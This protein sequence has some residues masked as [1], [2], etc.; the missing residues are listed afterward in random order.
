MFP[1]VSAC[2][3]YD[4]MYQIRQYVIGSSIVLWWCQYGRS[5]LNLKYQKLDSVSVNCGTPCDT[6]DLTIAFIK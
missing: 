6:H 4:S 2:H 5:V 1:F 3:K